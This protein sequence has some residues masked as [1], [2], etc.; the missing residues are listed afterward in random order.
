MPWP[1]RLGP[2]VVNPPL[3]SGFL[4]VDADVKFAELDG[5]LRRAG[6]KSQQTTG[7]VIA[8]TGRIETMTKVDDGKNMFLSEV[9]HVKYPD[10]QQKW[11]FE[12]VEE[13]GK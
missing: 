5:N 10:V 12:L 6:S 1:R 7:D 9:D 13:F 4:A 2:G 11:R 3:D 8:G